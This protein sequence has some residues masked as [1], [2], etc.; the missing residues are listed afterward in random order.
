[1]GGNLED[2]ISL[3]HI[4][5][6]MPANCQL[7]HMLIVLWTAPSSV[8]KEGARHH[9]HIPLAPKLSRPRTPPPAAPPITSRSTT[10]NATTGTPQLGLIAPSTISNPL[11][12]SHYPTQ[13]RHTSALLHKHS[14]HQIHIRS[15]ARPLC[16]P[17]RPACPQLHNNSSIRTKSAFHTAAHRSPGP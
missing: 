13:C 11:A 10:H 1:M 14:R 16:A 5:R 2:L 3:S 7:D 17:P 12:R 15:Q 8:L 4:P 9:V 6:L